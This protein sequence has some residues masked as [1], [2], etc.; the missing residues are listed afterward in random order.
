MMVAQSVA[1]TYACKKEQNTVT[2]TR[3]LLCKHH[4]KMTA[5]GLQCTNT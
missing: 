3:T 5:T 4:V 2:L 1:N